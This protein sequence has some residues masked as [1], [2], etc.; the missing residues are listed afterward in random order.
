[1]VE[2]FFYSPDIQEWWEGWFINCSP[3][4][5]PLPSHTPQKCIGSKPPS[6]PQEGGL[7]SILFIPRMNSMYSFIVQEDG[8]GS[9]LFIP[10][11]ILMERF[12]KDAP[13]IPIYIS[14][15]HATAPIYTIILH[16]SVCRR[17]QT[18]RRNSCSIVSGDVSNWS[19][20]PKVHPVM[21]SRFNWA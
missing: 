11:G 21:S 2:V 13:D 6:V 16:K 19:H 20:P 9:F 3:Y 8:V 14:K 18:A 10:A 15:A 12:F 4:K 7:G 17:S 5:H 1:M